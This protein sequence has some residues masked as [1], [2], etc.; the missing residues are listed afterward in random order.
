MITAT[1]SEIWYDDLCSCLQV[2]VAHVLAARGWDALQAMGTG[3]RFTWDSGSWEPVEYFHPRLG[4][5]SAAF[6]LYHPLD[7]VWHV[8]ASAGEGRAQLDEALA[9]GLTPIVAVD[10]YHLPFRPA[11]HDVHAGHLVVVE[12]RDPAADAYA[13]LDPMPPAFRGPLP[14]EV[15]ER[16][17]ASANPDDGSDPFFAGSSPAWRW[18]E[19]RVLG[20]Q[21]ELT[22]PWLRDR[23]ADN[24]AALRGEG[25]P[26]LS[27]LLGGLPERVA[28]GDDTPLREL[29]AA[30][31]PA[32]AEAS[33]HAAFLARAARS[34]GRPALAETARWVDLVAH[35]WTGV[36][37]AAAHGT[38][39]PPA[40]AAAVARHGGTLLRRWQEALDHVETAMERT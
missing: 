12:G 34:L 29:Y 31:W 38:A 7:M 13:V 5:L 16:A 26:A 14:R 8:P 23:L 3:W 40:A 21:P 24:L 39:D 28:G 37:V 19:V 25:L 30:G 15:L 1:R 2:D 33:V 6:G 18:L 20:P 17:R 35:G 10:N 22:W 36:R 4:S 32:Q 9:R 11:Y 27:S